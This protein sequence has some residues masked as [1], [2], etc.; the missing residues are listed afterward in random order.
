M[1][2]EPS[3]YSQVVSDQQDRLRPI[4]HIQVLS[5]GQVFRVKTVM[6][7]KMFNQEEALQN[8]ANGLLAEVLSEEDKLHK[9]DKTYH[10]SPKD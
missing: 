5:I 9:S 1:Q 7:L 6:L 10:L 2:N 4:H 8:M 3:I